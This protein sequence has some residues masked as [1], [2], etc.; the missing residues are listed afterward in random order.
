MQELFGILKITEKDTTDDNRCYRGS[1]THNSSQ[2][3]LV[4]RSALVE[5]IP[6]VGSPVPSELAP[7]L[8]LFSGNWDRPATPAF[9]REETQQ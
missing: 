3:R 9:G 1:V 4:V 2:S 7:E 8:V 5:M 6:G